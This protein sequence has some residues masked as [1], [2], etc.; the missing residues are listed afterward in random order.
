M[1]D[2]YPLLTRALEGV[3]DPTPDVRRNVYERARA[4]LIAQMRNLNPPIADADIMRECLALDDAVQRIEQYFAPLPAKPAFAQGDPD[5]VQESDQG[6]DQGYDRNYDQPYDNAYECAHEPF[7]AQPGPADTGG[8]RHNWNEAPATDLRVQNG[9]GY[10]EPAQPERRGRPRVALQPPS[11]K[12]GARKRGI[13]LFAT[14][15]SVVAVIAGL[16]IWMKFRDSATT[17]DAPPP[18]AAAPEGD[19]EVKPKNAERVDGSSPTPVTSILRGSSSFSQR[20]ILLEGIQR[21][22]DSAPPRPEDPPYTT[23]GGGGVVEARRHECR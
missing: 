5:Y 13:I 18:V 20:A 11:T 7:A 16:A 3:P 22:P 14:I 23:V 8:A 12:Q 17:Q 19:T 15:L 21:G 1:A 2:Y 4:A 6:Y 10:P 9:G